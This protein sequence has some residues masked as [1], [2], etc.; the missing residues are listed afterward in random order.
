MT[1]T[2]EHQISTYL[3]AEAGRVEVTDQLDAIENDLLV[4]PRAHVEQRRRRLAP[5]AGV[6][7]AV[8][9]VAGLALVAQRSGQPSAG[10]AVGAA[11]D[12]AVDASAAAP[13]NLA[14]LPTAVTEP[15]VVEVPLP[16]GAV[17]N[18]IEPTCV[19]TPDPEVLECSIAE[20][21][22][23]HGTFDYT[24][25]TSLIVD[26]TSHVSGGCRSTNA[27]ATQYL[28]YLGTR[29]VDEAIVGPD[30]LGQWAPREFVAG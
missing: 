3:R 30:Y 17:L 10:D 23:P 6:A 24:G 18:G 7:A 13:A 4:L 9:M 27:D 1:D 5:L 21:P 11:P 8:L 2:L 15:P 29:A 26:D 16:D 20:F 14:P 28:C 25:Y 19:E 12:P 22:E